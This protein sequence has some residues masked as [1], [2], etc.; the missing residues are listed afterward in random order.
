MNH[1]CVFVVLH[2]TVHY[3]LRMDIQHTLAPYVLILPRRVI[4]PLRSQAMIRVKEHGS[5]TDEKDMR[6]AYI[7]S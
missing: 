2:S 1:V 6:N 3:T 7:R 5:Q 4:P